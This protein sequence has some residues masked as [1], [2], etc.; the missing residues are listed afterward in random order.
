M[1]A[2]QK[3]APTIV[4]ANDDPSA[5]RMLGPL[6]GIARLGGDGAVMLADAVDAWV[7]AARSGDEIVYGIGHLPTW[8]KGPARMR[9]MAARGFVHLFH[10][11]S[12]SPKHYVA[13][14]GSK[15]WSE[16]ALLPPP[17]IARAVPCYA[18]HLAALSR[19]LAEIAAAR[20]PCPSNADLA[21]LLDLPTAKTAEYLL[22]VLTRSGAI[23]RTPV[24][25]PPYRIITIVKTGE[26]TSA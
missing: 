24:Q 12:H 20:L 18:A 22:R 11:R 26:R 23:A 14:R 3:V 2:V 1:M 13:Q 16:A 5:K 6:E 7:S 21:A 25:G 9:E 10:D 17:R 4:A 19:H 15:P 8:S